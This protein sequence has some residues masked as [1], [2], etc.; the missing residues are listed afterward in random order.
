MISKCLQTFGLQPQIS[1]VFHDH[2]LGQEQFF[3]TV[4]QNNLGNKIP[5]SQLLSLEIEKT[6]RYRKIAS[7]NAVLDM[8]LKVLLINKSGFWVC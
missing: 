4:D 6:T 1:K 3:L 2:Y 7:I 5:I 8:Y